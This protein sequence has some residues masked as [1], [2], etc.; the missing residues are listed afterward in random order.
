MFSHFP[1][2]K[3]TFIHYNKYAQQ[4]IT[5]IFPSV[6][7]DTI[8]SFSLD[9]LNTILLKNDNSNW[10]KMALP[11]EVQYS[12]TY[13][14]LH[15]HNQDNNLLYLGGNDYRMKPQFG[16]NDASSGWRISMENKD[17]MITFGTPTACNIRGEIRSIK[18]IDESIIYGINDK[19]VQICPIHH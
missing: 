16:I 12:S 3:K 9:E 4:D 14:F 8:I 17:N 2:I 19:N 13:A 10:V 1:F 6:D 18:D 7:Y 11:H 15:I 5:G